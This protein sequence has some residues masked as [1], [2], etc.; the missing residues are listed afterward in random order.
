[1]HAEFAANVP[2]WKST[3]HLPDRGVID[4]RRVRQHD[5]AGQERVRANHANAVR[6]HAWETHRIE[7]PVELALDAVRREG[8]ASSTEQENGK[9]EEKR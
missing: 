1:V 6:R 3:M 2:G 5:D 7:L 9:G 8:R 4:R